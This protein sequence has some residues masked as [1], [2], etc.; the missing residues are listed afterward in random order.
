VMSQSAA[1]S[2]GRACEMDKFIPPVR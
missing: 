2:R 1:N